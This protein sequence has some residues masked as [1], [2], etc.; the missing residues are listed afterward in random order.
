MGRKPASAMRKSQPDCRRWTH[1]RRSC[2]VTNRNVIEAQRDPEVSDPWITKPFPT[3][4]R[5]DGELVQRKFTFLFGEICERIR[6][7][8]LPESGPG[9]GNF[10]RASRSQQRP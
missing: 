10:I 3:G 8:G 9:G 5:V 4:S 2:E 7:E 1:S 6:D